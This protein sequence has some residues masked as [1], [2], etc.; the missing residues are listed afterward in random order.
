MLRRQHDRSHIDG[1]AAF[2]A[3]GQLAFR[4]RAQRRLLA[5]FAHLGEAAEDRM[6]ILD[7]RRHQVG[8]LVHGV[9]EHDALV[10][11]AFVLV[12]GGVHALGDM[13]GLLVQEVQHVAGV[14][15]E[16]VLLVADVLDAVARDLGDTAHVVLELVLI[17]QTD[18]SP[19][20]DHA[21]R[22]EGFAGDTR[23][24][25]FGDECVENGV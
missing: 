4:V 24:G 2:V 10:A 19:D 12:V 7:R 8:R 22:G 18:L 21:G 5:R 11:R 3:H 14:P 17:A 15:V 20:D 16:L 1:L 25:F 9:A 23:L 13:G 6:G